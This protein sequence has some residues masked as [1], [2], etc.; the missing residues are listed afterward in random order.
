MR[1]RVARSSLAVVAIAAAAVGALLLSTGDG[2]GPASTPSTDRRA[3]T[4]ATRA[5]TTTVAPRTTTTTTLV[6]ALPA[7]RLADP[8][9]FGT[10]YSDTVTG[11]LTFRGNPS[12]S[13]HG[14]GPVPAIP[15]I[16]WRFPESPMCHDSSEFGETRT[17]CGMGWTGQP[18]VFEREGRT[19]LVFGAYDAKVHFLDAETGARL[20]PDFETGDIIKG[21]VTIDPDGYP[22]VYTGSR[23]NQL[24]VLAIDGGEVRE[25]WRLDARSIE[26]RKWNDDW[27]GS[28]L[29]LHDLL[30]EGGENSQFHVVR[31]HRGYGADGRVTVAPELVFH[32]PGWDDEL[33]GAIGDNQVSIEGSVVVVDDTV[34]F[35][36]SGGLVQGWDLGPLRRG[37]GAPVRTLR[38]WTGDD[39]DASI[40]ADDQGY[41]FVGS[42]YERGTARSDEVGQLFKL[43]PRRPDAPVVWSVATP[44]S[45]KGGTWSSAA[46]VGDTVLWPTRPGAV[47]AVARDT[48]EVRWTVRLPGPVMGSPVIVDG[49]WL[50]GDCQGFLHAFDLR[51]PHT[52]P[53]EL[54]SVDLGG[55]VEATP[56][57]WRGTVYIGSRGGFLYALRD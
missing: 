30:I 12:R 21:S 39:T 54:W 9:R 5:P 45:D 8:R 47:F 29:V 42:E 26:P 31:L 16:A 4:T 20:L 49:V 1:P 14:E 32:T 19:W 15:D 48:G 41:L 56:V 35:A 33:L 7:D 40:V 44:K 23:D 17:W 57:V 34:Y 24:R 37:E 36:N 3:T 27:D 13:F 52:A 53:A 18:A 11:V 25:L 51:D 22:L 43:D 28:P 46:I 10:P 55:C 50:Q 38:F 6:P 2:G